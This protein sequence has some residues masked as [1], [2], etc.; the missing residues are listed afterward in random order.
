[1]GFNTVIVSGNLTRD[2]EV[3]YLPSG[4]AVA[5]GGLAVNRNFKKG[6]DWVKE[7]LFLNIEGWE[8]IA[9]RLGDLEK[10]ALV[11]IQGD[12]RD[13]S[14]EKDGV[15]RS[16]VKVNVIS[17]ERLEKFTRSE[18]ADSSSSNEERQPVA[19]HAGLEVA[20]DGQTEDE[21]PF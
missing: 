9:E 2:I 17:V 8:R 3:K 10:G 1:M 15:K 5:K 18:D 13:D 20:E 16:G 21:I 19:A 12:L 6:D 7:T 14:W 11:T 4:K